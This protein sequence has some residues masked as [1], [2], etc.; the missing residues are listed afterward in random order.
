[1][2]QNAELLLFPKQAT[3]VIIVSEQLKQVVVYS[4]SILIWIPEKEN[5]SFFVVVVIVL[6]LKLLF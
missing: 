1:M 3:V 6:Y 2:A 5:P 4:V